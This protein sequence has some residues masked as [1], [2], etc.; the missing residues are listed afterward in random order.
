MP[1]F[2]YKAVDRT[3]RPARGGLDA[4]NEVDLELRLRRM[5]LDLITFRQIEQNASARGRGT[6]T[7]QDLINFCFDLEQMSRSGIPLLDGIVD[8]RESMDNPRFREV[9]TGIAEDMEGGKLF[10]QCLAAHPGVFSSVFVSL[11]RAGEQTGRLTEVFESLGASIKWQDE[12]AAMTKRL[13]IYPAMVL[14]V[15]TAVMF[16]LLIYL[17]PQVTA[18]LKTMNVALPVQTRVLIAVSGF[19]V[20]YWPLLIGLPVLV[21]VSLTLWVQSSEKA[22]YLWDY[23]KLR[24]PVTGPIL[25]KII[26]A[27]FASFFALM[28][29][30]G[31]TI[32]DALKTSEDIVGN[33]VIADGLQR[34]G[35]Q[36]NGG[37]SLTETFRN[38]GM[39]PPLVIRMLRTGESTGALDAA[40]LN[41]N[42]F[43]TRDVKESVDRGLKLL[44][45]ALTMVLG[46]MLALIMWS[47]LTPVYDLFGKMKY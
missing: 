5:G 19:V 44:E 24:L 32:L 12:L 33:R 34:A 25:Q 38:L 11:V 8:L 16:F 29:Q 4:A 40:L 3:G 6:I 1:A 43:Y 45:P 21:G 18:L 2:T 9:L 37:E 30:S 46:V 15:V 41:I 20:K 10:S 42:Y 14:V 36:I 39:F 13:L 26:L 28:Y 22:R 31:I 47:V 35:A 7:R 17:V 27:R 23:T